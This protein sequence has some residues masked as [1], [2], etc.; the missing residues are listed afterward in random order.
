[1]L[2][3]E[4]K[5]MT[6]TE[7]ISGVSRKAIDGVVK[8]KRRVLPPKSDDG[9]LSYCIKE[10]I[11]EIGVSRLVEETTISNVKHKYRLRRKNVEI[12]MDVVNYERVPGAFIMSKNDMLFFT[13][14]GMENLKPF[15]VP[16][17][18]MNLA[19]DAFKNLELIDV[20]GIT[21]K[22]VGGDMGMSYPLGLMIMGK[23]PFFKLLTSPALMNE[24]GITEHH[25]YICATPRFISHEAGSSW[26]YEKKRFVP[27]DG[28]GEEEV[29]SN[30]E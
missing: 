22:V 20:P 30:K 5:I 23:H 29:M 3:G 12:E 17:A 28:D 19:K 6:D 13:K 7:K 9:S 2:R 24:D 14:G 26:K 16:G 15:K 8:I 25:Y 18:E 4:T 1:M 10:E 11:S 27:A 21:E